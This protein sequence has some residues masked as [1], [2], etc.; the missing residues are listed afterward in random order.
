MRS[1]SLAACEM[2]PLFMPM[3]LPNVLIKAHSSIHLVSHTIANEKMYCLKKMSTLYFAYRNTGFNTTGMCDSSGEYT[4]GISGLWWN[5]HTEPRA[6]PW[7][8]VSPKAGQQHSTPE[9]G[10]C[11][12]LHLAPSSSISAPCN[13]TSTTTSR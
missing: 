12:L 9:R 4:T 5:K 11:L 6:T 2:K 8:I 13:F 7:S 1:S 3:F 10:P